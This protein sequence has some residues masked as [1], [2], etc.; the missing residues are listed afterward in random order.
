[1]NSYDVEFRAT[2]LQSLTNR[3]ATTCLYIAD[4]LSKQEFDLL[5]Q[6]LKS[7]VNSASVLKIYEAYLD[8]QGR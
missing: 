2:Q 6:L 5:M 7:G 1:M 8:L 4:H 3:S